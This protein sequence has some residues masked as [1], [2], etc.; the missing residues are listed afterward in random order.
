MRPHFLLTSISVPAG[1]LVLYAWSLYRVVQWAEHV[2]NN[3][4]VSSFLP[5]QYT[6]AEDYA[7]TFDDLY[8]HHGYHDHSKLHFSWEGHVVDLLVSTNLENEA[9]GIEAVRSVLVLGCS[10]GLGARWL[11][12]RGL[13]TWGVDVAERAVQL[14]LATR[15]RTCEGPEP[16]FV[17]A[18]L[19]HL[20]YADGRFDAGLSSDVLEHI[21]PE[22]VPRVVS[23]IS[24]V[25]RR[26]LVL[27]IA[28]WA[29]D[30]A[31]CQDEAWWG[32]RFGAEGWQVRRAYRREAPWPGGFWAVLVLT[33]AR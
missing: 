6:E 5:G 17:R 33:R 22:D 15:G 29:D 14:A 8:Q 20:P 2:Y 25:V 4:E 12:D 9:A 31:T 32:Q 1:A 18:S 26:L 16:C 28:G 19:T 21:Q 27:Q 3:T 11:A 30:C 7:H 24:R 23:E 10:H 13:A